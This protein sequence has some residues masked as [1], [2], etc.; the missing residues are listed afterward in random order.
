MIVETGSGLAGADS[1]VSEAEFDAYVE[2][3]GLTPTAGADVEAALVRASAWIDWR[4]A[5]R[6]SGIRLKGRLQGLAWPRQYGVDRDGYAVAADAVPVE[7]K[8]ATIEAA[9]REMAA[10]GSLAPDVTADSSLVKR[11]KLGSI[12]VEYAVPTASLSGPVFSQIDG[13]LAPLLGPGG[14]GMVEIIRA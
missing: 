8:H 4:F 6:F 10:P 12:E 11:E 5:A 7:I 1:Y 13:I 3:R 14:P 9:L 2:A